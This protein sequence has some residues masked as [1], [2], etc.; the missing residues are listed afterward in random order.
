MQLHQPLCFY[1]YFFFLS[2]I[3][4][5]I[6]CLLVGQSTNPS[7]IAHLNSSCHL[8]EFVHDMIEKNNNN[9]KIHFYM[10]LYPLISS[11]AHQQLFFFYV[12]KLDRN[13]S[14]SL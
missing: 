4:S 1:Y 2:M 8:E 9:N 7:R 3:N 14:I 10:V 6:N 11:Q 13:N 12:S 5:D